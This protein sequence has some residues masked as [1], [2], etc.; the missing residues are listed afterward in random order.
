MGLPGAFPGNGVRRLAPPPPIRFLEPGPEGVV[1]GEHQLPISPF[2]HP[3]GEVKAENIPT[4][5]QSQAAR[6]QEG[7]AQLLRPW[8]G[9]GVPPVSCSP[10]GSEGPDSDP[11][12][13]KVLRD[14]SSQEPETIA[15]PRPEI[16][17]RDG[18]APSEKVEGLPGRITQ[19]SSPF[20][21]CPE[22]PPLAQRARV[23]GDLARD[24]S[25]GPVREPAKKNLTSAG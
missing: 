17:P 2:P 12:C 11:G 19:E 22:V 20:Q 6:N 9:E 10:S 5:S 16:V 1:H 18:L 7:W 14:I 21:G 3:P 8:R 4:Q 24:L 13:Q 15:D 23:K 25:K